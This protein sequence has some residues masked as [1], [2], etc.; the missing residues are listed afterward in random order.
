M[1][2]YITG[3]THGF[4]Q[5]LIDR[6]DKSN[7][8]LTQNDILII[9]G[10]FGFGFDLP[11]NIRDFELLKALPFTICFIDGN[12]E[13]FPFLNSFPITTW[14]G[15][16]VHRIHDNI[17]HLMRGQCFTLDNKTYFTMGGAYSV[18]RGKKKKGFDL[19]SEELPN[20]EEYRIASATLE[21]HG[22]RFDYILTHTVPN[23]A[24]YPL[25]FG[26]DYHE[27][28]LTGYLQW[29]YTKTEF[30]KWFAGHFHTDKALLNGNLRI[31]YDDVVRID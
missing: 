9:T 27:A 12:H 18:D 3:D 16:N 29:V 23:A 7:C 2:I 14:N 17:I 6:L 5:P 8:N 20:N 11:N 22:Y 13:N 28:E 1:S 4:Y 25:G 24:L 15:G 19:F 10:D 30:S 26:P 21:R 31:L